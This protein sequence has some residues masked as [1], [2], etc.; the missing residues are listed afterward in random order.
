MPLLLSCSFSSLEY[1]ICEKEVESRRAVFGTNAIADKQLDSF[2]KLCWKAV[3]DFVLI[4]LIVLGV[5][6]IV[7][8]MTY[9]REDGEKCRACWI[10]G[11]AILASV[12]IVVLVTTGIDY[13][14]Q[15]AFI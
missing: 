5:I 15:F 3:Q 9:G 14:K 6:S 4:M 2:C 10:E 11:A 1:G 12:G 8:E 7:V 13:T